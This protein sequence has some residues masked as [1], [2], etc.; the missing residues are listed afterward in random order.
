VFIGAY[1]PT[2]GVWAW[3]DGSAWDEREMSGISNGAYRDNSEGNN[4]DE[5]AYCNSACSRAHAGDDSWVGIHD[6]GTRN[7]E[8]TEANGNH[9]TTGTRLS[10]A[11]RLDADQSCSAETLVD[12]SAT[13]S[14]AC[15][16]GDGEECA[17]GIPKNC[18]SQ[19][20]DAVVEFERA[21]RSIIHTIPGMSATMDRALE[22]CRSRERSGGT[23]YVGVAQRMSWSEA[24]NL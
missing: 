21:C 17:Q 20:G 23:D 6:W 9:W 2:E 7:G 15:Q 24:R 11:C 1:E 19:C 10:Y 16:C 22:S 4:E 14:A 12:R 8:W 5:M 13:M 3:T 18:P